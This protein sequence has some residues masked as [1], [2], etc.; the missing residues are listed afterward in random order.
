MNA[1]LAR[2]ASVSLLSLLAMASQPGLAA[3]A[4]L[5]GTDDAMDNCVDRSNAGQ[6]DTDGDGF[7][8][9]CDGDLNNDGKVNS[10]D[11][12]L[13]KGRLGGND[14]DADLNGD[15]SVDGADTALLRQL[16]LKAPGPTAVKLDPALVE[17]PPAV[18]DVAIFLLSPPLADGRN[19]L[20]TLDLR[21]DTPSDDGSP[22]TLVLPEDLPP[23]LT[24]QSNAP[25]ACGAATCPARP[26]SYNDMG[27][28][29][30]QTAGDGIYSGL[31]R[32]DAEAAAAD[33][34]DYLERLNRSGNT[35][36]SSF[37][38]RERLS[39]ET[40][41]VPAGLA[42][43][44]GA[45]PLGAAPA[46]GPAPP[47]VITLPI[48]PPF[49]VS[50]TPVPLLPVTLA[51]ST[52]PGKTLLIADPKV[53]AHPQ[54]TFDPCNTVGGGNTVDPDAPW[55]F[56]TLLRG[57]ASPSGDAGAASTLLSDWLQQWVEPDPS[58]VNG[59][60][61][62]FDVA[63]T[64]WAYFHGI[65]RL[66]VHPDLD[67]LPLRLLAVSNRIDLARAAGYGPGS[68][69]ELRFVFGLLF[70]GT[71]ASGQQVCT[72][73][74]MTVILEYKLP[75]M[76]CAALQ[77]Y[78]KAWVA[79]NEHDLDSPAGLASY[80]AALEALTDP[81]TR[82]NAA[83]T[84]P[85]GS[86]IAQVRTNEQ[87]A[88]AGQ[89]FL[90]EFKLQSATTGAR[91]RHGKLIGTPDGTLN[92]TLA[93]SDYMLIPTL[94]PSACRTS[95]SAILGQSHCVPD[96][97]AGAPFGG[98][99]V[100]NV[101]LAW[102]GAPPVLTPATG[103]IKLIPAEWPLALGERRPVA[104]SD[105]RFKFASATCNG[106]HSGETG[107]NGSIGTGSSVP[108]TSFVHIDPVNSD[109]AVPGQAKL[110]GF[111]TGIAGIPD[112]VNFAP[113]H[114][115]NDLV[116]RAQMLD[117]LATSSCELTARLPLAADFPH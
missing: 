88:G 33:A 84:N 21:I 61:L 54:Y 110:S 67:D 102:D 83:P 51:A 81:V 41:A 52:S 92:N 16:F 8:N 31:L 17:D 53:V 107:T 27:L 82:P 104:A 75:A 62:P 50:A 80:L 71:D 34:D 74:P 72:P 113:L 42:G 109:P 26:V 76:G 25:L 48:D 4:D 49:E 68:P 99:I 114:D 105:L 7:G 86:A 69:G 39:T 85:N 28:L 97:Y 116:R 47:I 90:R 11:L 117:A 15:G 45:S 91:L 58:A 2:T 96:S 103:T 57:I 59:F 108:S 35:R 73:V 20:A 112:A 32:F 95:P 19:A 36:V 9:A 56:K 23:A 64:I 3:D 6:R 94:A 37:A 18:R 43:A 66:P 79:L 89:W 5:D 87:V 70:K 65:K 13:F 12:G 24:M 98:G 38:G 10:L 93:L 29:G 30:D 115:F 14:P 60:P 111:L 55:S 101:D 106:C 22:S 1:Y 77:G 100:L 44:R 63:N 40:F 46:A 78:A